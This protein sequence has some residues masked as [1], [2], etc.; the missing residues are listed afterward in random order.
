M[1]QI[2]LLDKLNL[3]IKTE[4]NT[5]FVW[6]IVRKKWIQLTP[7]EHV[8]QAMVHYF[9]EQLKYP[10]K[11]IAIEKQIKFGALIKR[12]DIVVYNRN[13]EPWMMVECKAPAIPITQNTLHQLLQYHSQIPCSYWL[14]SNGV[15]SHCADARDI[16]AIRW[17]QDIPVYPVSEQ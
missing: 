3:N 9:I 8:R 11:L 2:D 15:A 1:L 10:A 4:N 13:H 17:I 14:L 6:D 12:Y 7:E 16:N 5:R